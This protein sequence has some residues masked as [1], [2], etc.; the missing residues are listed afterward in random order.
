[1]SMLPTIE[2]NK[3]EHLR[4]LSRLDGRRW[5]SLTEK[6]RCPCC[7]TL[8]SGYEIELVGGTRNQG[9]LRLQCPRCENN[10]AAKPWQPAEPR[11]VT[12]SHN[13]SAPHGKGTTHK[14]RRLPRAGENASRNFNLVPAS[15]HG[16]A[17]RFNLFSPH[18]PSFGKFLPML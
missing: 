6:R 4:A 11:E 17:S 9:P 14:R 3:N 1:M 18:L 10:D 12:V 5:R 13:R 7:Q 8:S 16:W 2:L 15:W